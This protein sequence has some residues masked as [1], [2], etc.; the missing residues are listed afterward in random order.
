MTVSS[1]VIQAP[2]SDAGQRV[3]ADAIKVLA[4]IGGKA[5]IKGLA[6]GRSDTFRVNPLL[7][8]VEEGWNSRDLSTPDN[9]AHIDEL[10]RSIAANGVR[11]PLKA[12]LSGD[13]LI[14][15][16]GHCRLA[17]VKRAIEVY[18]AE[19]MTVPVMTEERYAND[20]DRLLTQIVSNSGK[21][22]TT[23]EQGVVYRR[24]SALGWTN[25]Q[26]AER[27]GKSVTHVIMNL[28]LQ[29]A[30]PSVIA[31]I[32]EGKVAP[33][34]AWQTMKASATEE[35]AVEAL[36]NGIK[37]AQ[38]AGRSKATAKHIRSGATAAG[39][40]KKASLKACFEKAKIDNSMDDKVTIE[41]DP[42]TFETVRRL[43]NL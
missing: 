27:T 2:N 43:L 7:L 41:F 9:Q 17:A 14:V 11:E 20:A 29:A 8:A 36:E 12:Y 34:L 23:L 40:P 16:N 19:I 28:E 13:R 1:F 4:S 26:I 31:M 10:A 35:A 38:D 21:P 22:L 18:G 24:L 25:D 30:P 42:E 6:S 15:T 37:A 39:A 5:G 3:A 33:T 32:K